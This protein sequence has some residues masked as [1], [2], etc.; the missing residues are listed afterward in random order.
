MNTYPTLPTRMGPDGTHYKIEVDE[1]ANGAIRTRHMSD[2]RRRIFNLVH[3]NIT[4]AQKDALEAFFDAQ[5]G[6]F[7]YTRT[8]ETVETYAVLFISAPVPTYE[9]GGRYTVSVTLREA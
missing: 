6:P 9:K 4:A 8:R 5:V 3:P 1:A 7:T 2:R